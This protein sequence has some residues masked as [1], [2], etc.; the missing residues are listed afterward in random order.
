M[1]EHS[2]ASCVEIPPLQGPPAEPWSARKVWGLLKC[3][4][5]AAILASMSIGAGETIVVVR[6]GAW[7]AYE[8]LWVVLLSCLVKGVFVTYMLGRYTA[9]SGESV[10]SRLV[11]LPG[12]RGWLLLLIVG[13]ELLFAPL[14]WVAIARPCGNLL[15]HLVGYD[16]LAGFVASDASGTQCE[17]LYTLL[18]IIA[19]LVVSLTL[20]YQRLERQQ[21]AICG[22]LVVGT[23]IGTVM[24]KPDLWTAAAGTLSMGHWPERLPAW[25]PEDARR[26]PL[27]TLAT[28]FSYVGGS[29]TAYIAYANWVG[30]RRW[31]LTGHREIEQIRRR[32]ARSPCID[33][34]PDD[35][36]QRRR[37][38]QLAA[39]L[40]WDISMGAVVLFLVTAAFMVAGAAVLYDR[41]SAFSGWS[42]LTD[43]AYIWRNIHPWLVPVYYVTVIAA[44]WGTLTALPEIYS[45][46]THEFFS[47]IWPRR[48]WDFRLIRRVIVGW[49]LLESVFLLWAQFEFELLIQVAGFLTAN[50][51]VAG[52][53][54]AA[55]YLNHKLPPAYRTRRA[56][57]VCAAAAT[58][59]LIVASWMS[60]Y[61]LVRKMMREEPELVERVEPWKGT[62]REM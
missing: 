47:A 54:V 36:E 51:A 58:A 56:V 11:R 3:F 38:R 9:I 28:V 45:R 34:L 59:V 46:V 15:H 57:L 10:G 4:G 55:F 42:L 26:F 25:A 20:T 6:T 43:Q 49:I 44:L 14:A 53:A 31:G 17:N 39:P 37:L 12:P 52:V 30:I 40:R 33:Y 2:P 7:A 32:A 1:P 13:A 60:A 62:L 8:L 48:R 23:L 29:V 35:P 61:G 50:L 16:F 27:L 21:I 5:P 24:V 18:F 19:A 22:I 41:Q